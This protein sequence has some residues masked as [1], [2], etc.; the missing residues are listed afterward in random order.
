MSQPNTATFDG[1]TIVRWLLFFVVLIALT[2][3]HLLVL[4]RGLGT[5]QAMEQAQ[6]GRQVARGEGFQTKV[7]KPLEL[8]L[9]EN[10]EGSDVALVGL[11]DTYHSP[12]NPLVLGSV[13]K[14]VGADQEDSW[15]IPKK[16]LI[17]P[18]DRVVALVSTVFF[19]MA[20]GVTYLLVSRI[21]DGKIAGFTAAL[22]LLCDL[23][24]QFSQ[25][26]LPQ[27]L[28]LLLFTCGL[29]FSFRTIE[30]QEEG[31][32]SFVQPLLAALFFSLMV[33]T[34]WITA[35]IFFGFI[36]FAAIAFRPRGLIALSSLGILFAAVIWPLLRM[37]DITGQPFGSAR[38]VFYNGLS[39]GSEAAIMR[40]LDLGSAPLLLDGLLLKILGTTLVQASNLIPFLGGILAAPIFFVALLHPFKRLAIARFR[41]LIALMWL[42]AAVGMAIFG[43]NSTDA[44]HPNQIH[45]LF[46]PV[47]A[48]Y[49]L[50]FLSILWSR[51]E[52]ANNIPFLRNAHYYAIM[53]LSA[54]PMML[55]LPKNVKMYMHVVDKGGWPQWPPYYPLVLNRG[56]SGWVGNDP[57]SPEIVVTDQPW[58]VAWYADR[59]ALWLPKTMADFTTLDQKATDQG[60]RLTGILITP[61]S[62]DAAESSVVSMDNPDFAPLIFDGLTAAV[63]GP[64]VTQPGFPIWDKAPRISAIH[65]RFPNRYP[66][67]GQDMVYYSEGR[68]RDNEE[69][70]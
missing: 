11:R 8:H 56:L 49:G 62:R 1:A 21:F 44:L 9:A 55:T 65:N 59:Y 36:I 4:F 64:T 32:S 3:I 23:F 57:K 53:A 47:M 50:A 39:S 7:I 42:C 12:L 60:T 24:W 37:A 31:K 28:L 46:A 26:G 51:L 15:K 30:N 10:Q 5:P 58:A 70:D 40:T 2:L 20:I 13:F 35:W 63:T 16:Q 69:E 14:L 34:H 66:L 67:I 27:M 25:S 68:L 48:A 52:F 19:M 22:M 45:I 29:Y 18:L 54:A 6:L 17:Y 38:F 33:L 41:W 61:A 43:I